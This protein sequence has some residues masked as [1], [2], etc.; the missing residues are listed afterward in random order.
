MRSLTAAALIVSAVAAS[1]TVA[2]AAPTLSLHWGSCP[3]PQSE[4]GNRYN[5]GALHHTITVTAHGLSGTFR[6][7]D[8]GLALK[9]YERGVGDAW[10]FD[11]GGCNRGHVTFNQ[12][13]VSDP[14]PY[15]AGA[16]EQT[17]YLAPYRA[18]IDPSGYFDAA[19]GLRTYRAFDAIAADPD[20]TYTLAR[21]D[22]DLGTSCGCLDRPMCIS[23]NYMSYFDGDGLEHYFAVD[24]SYLTWNDPYA[25]ACS[26]GPLCP[27]SG[28]GPSSSDTMC[29]ANPTPASNRSWGSV[30]ASY[31]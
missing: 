27:W 16:H 2:F 21:F 19:L 11:E 23:L 28:C 26:S 15:L 8:I 24:R 29:V 31:R 9:A 20:Q 3:L 13:P 5:D 30:K 1:S 4:D 25:S 22:M 14:C 10:R 18:E 6:G 7:F 12:V 17:F